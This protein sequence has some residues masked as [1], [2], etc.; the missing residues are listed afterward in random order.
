[1]K[2]VI[3]FLATGFGFGNL[4]PAP[5]TWGSL[6]AVIIATIW[7]IPL[8]FIIFS[9]F[10]GIYICQK[11]EENLQEH[12][13]PRIVFDEMVGIWLAV[14]NIPL[15]LF[16]L[17]FILFRIFDIKKF[18]PINRLQ[19]FPGGIGIMLDDIAAGILA[20]IIIAL[21]IYLV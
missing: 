1:M 4:K 10:L 20:R 11:A 17:A 15:V 19:D 13:S 12:D 2:F 16:P 18:Y 6:I 3:N 9:I 21:I 7:T 5:G 14:W 8:E